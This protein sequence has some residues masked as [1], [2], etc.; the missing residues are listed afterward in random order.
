MDESNVELFSSYKQSKYNLERREYARRKVCMFA[1]VIEGE[2]QNIENYSIAKQVDFKGFVLH[3]KLE[4]QGFTVE[5]L[6]SLD[7][8]YHRPA[9]ELI[10]LT[11]KQH[12]KVHKEI[13]R[14]L[15]FCD[16]T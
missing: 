15:H 11:H 14:L 13:R 9:N 2:E 1:Y 5:Q 7:L 6:K 10:F 4:E 3:H 8:Y 16:R 12:A